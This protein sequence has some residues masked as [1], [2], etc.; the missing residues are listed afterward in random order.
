MARTTLYLVRHGEQAATGDD[1]AGLSSRGG[2]QAAGLAERLAG[3]TF[4]ALHHSAL[5]RARETAQILAGR[6]TGVT[7]HTCDLVL[8]RTPTPGPGSRYPRRYDAFFAGVPV[9]ERDPGGERIGAAVA[10]L[11]E[12]GDHDR[13]DLV[14][15][16]NFVIGW[17]VRHVLDAPEWRWLGLDQANCGLTVVAWETGRAPA[18]VGYNDVGHL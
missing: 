7:P 16:H 3:T 13:T 15:T 8:D 11:G 10:A 14:V 5:T 12:I 1:D 4:D 2:E 9:P 6:L 18:L 17:F